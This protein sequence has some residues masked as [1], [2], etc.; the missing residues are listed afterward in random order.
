M[1]NTSRFI[2]EFGFKAVIDFETGFGKDSKV[3]IKWVFSSLD[4]IQLG[5]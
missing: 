5:I 2:K 1:L 3:V 4:Y